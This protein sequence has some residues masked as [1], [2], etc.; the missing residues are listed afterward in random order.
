MLYVRRLI[1]L[2]VLGAALTGCSSGEKAADSSAQPSAEPGTGAQTPAVPSSQP[3]GNDSKDIQAYFAQEGTHPEQAIIGLM[4]E[5]KRT[6]DI[7]I[8]SI[9]Y[10]PIV[11]AIVDAADRGVSVRLITDREHAAE[12]GKQKDALKRIA[13]AGIPVKTNSHDGKMHLK[14]LVADTQSVEAG[15]FNYLKSSVEENDDVALIIHDAAVG[16]QFEDAFNTMWNDKDRFQD[17]QE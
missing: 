14:M 6:L 11:D 15:S 5:A 16:K 8:Y 7:A 2:A 3:S 10:E 4:N 12:K 1:I 9:N 13:K 17:Y